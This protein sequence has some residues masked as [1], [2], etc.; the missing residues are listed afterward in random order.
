M[1]INDLRALTFEMIAN[2]RENE[3]VGKHRG[4]VYR[5][6]SYIAVDDAAS[7]RS[8]F[9]TVCSDGRPATIEA[10]LRTDTQVNRDQAA[11]YAALRPETRAVL[12][13]LSIPHNNLGQLAILG[14]AIEGRPHWPSVNAVCNWSVR[15][16]L[17]EL[18]PAVQTV[19]DAIKAM[20][21]YAA[22]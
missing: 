22:T 11:A 4:K 6:A 16:R 13:R 21:E 1:T 8:F 3:G 10:G 14:N 20:Q 2:Y 15:Q 17:R 18:F 9:V 19:A 5:K 12:E 7:E